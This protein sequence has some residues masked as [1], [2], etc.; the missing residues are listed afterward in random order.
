MGEEQKIALGCYFCSRGFIELSVLGKHTGNFPASRPSRTDLKYFTKGGG[1]TKPPTSKIFQ[2]I[3]SGGF[4]HST[5]MN[6]AI[7]ALLDG[8]AGG[9]HPTE[10]VHGE[11]YP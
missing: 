7:P 6:G 2:R 3:R 1:S 9:T 11:P 8:G 4:T 5:C 10:E